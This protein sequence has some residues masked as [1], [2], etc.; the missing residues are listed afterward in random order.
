MILNEKYSMMRKLY[1]EFAEMMD[2]RLTEQEPEIRSNPVLIF[3]GFE[4][5]EAEYLEMFRELTKE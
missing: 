1:R 5:T 3:E 4:K 2:L